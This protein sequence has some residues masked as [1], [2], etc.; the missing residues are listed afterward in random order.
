MSK[1]FRK[2]KK[3]GT[4]FEVVESSTMMCVECLNPSQGAKKMATSE[5]ELL[6]YALKIAGGAEVVRQSF[7]KDK[8]M[9]S[10]SGGAT[11]GSIIETATAEGW[12]AT[13]NNIKFSDLLGMSKGSKEKSSRLTKRG[14]GR[15]EGGCSQAP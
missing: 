4:P 14:Q 11:V 7:I 5:K 3:C 10:I 12:L 6:E 9:K 2:C 1:Q 8:L 15:V 13:L